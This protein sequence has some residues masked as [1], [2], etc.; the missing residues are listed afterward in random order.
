MSFG[1]AR[2]GRQPEQ[3]GAPGACKHAERL[4]PPSRWPACL[5]QAGLLP[6]ALSAG[7]D[8]KQVDAFL[9]RLYG[10]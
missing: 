1:T 7:A 9:Y 6:L 10:M 5:R 2:R 8:R 3:G 4:A